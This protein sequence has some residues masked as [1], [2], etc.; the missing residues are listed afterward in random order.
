MGIRLFKYDWCSYGGLVPH[1]DHAGLLK[2]YQVMREALNGPRDVFSLCQYEWA[3]SEWGGR[4]WRQL[5]A[6]DGRH[7]RYVVERPGIG[8]GQAGHE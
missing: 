7:H 5:L 3:M 4:S 1:P 6:D 2:P 8:F